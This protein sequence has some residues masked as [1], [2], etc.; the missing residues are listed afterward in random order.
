MK[1]IS[2]RNDKAISLKA[3]AENAPHKHPQSSTT[4]VTTAIID[5]QK[6]LRRDRIFNIENTELEKE[7]SGVYLQL[8]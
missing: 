7:V 3:A 5:E 2:S 4:V 1:Q 6:A 8:L